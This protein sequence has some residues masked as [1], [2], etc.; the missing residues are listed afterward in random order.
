MFVSQFIHLESSLIIQGFIHKFGGA[1]LAFRVNM[2]VYLAHPHLQ[3]SGGIW[4]IEVPREA[5]WWHLRP[6]CVAAYIDLHLIGGREN[7]NVWVGSFLPLPDCVKRCICFPF[8]KPPNMQME[9]TSHAHAYCVLVCRNSFKLH[10]LI[11]FCKFL[12]SYS[13]ILRHI[14]YNSTGWPG[15]CWMCCTFWHLPSLSPHAT[16]V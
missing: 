8:Y 16:K 14:A 4:K 1:S 15:S 6:F 11:T 10:Y 3:W 7:F 5:I 12:L 13:V 9:V 2:W